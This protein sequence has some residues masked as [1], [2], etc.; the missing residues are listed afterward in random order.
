MFMGE[1]QHALDDKGRLTIPAKFRDGLGDNFIVTRGLDRCLFVYPRAEWDTMEEKVKSLP[2]AQADA[3]AFVRLLFSGAVEAELDKQG[4]VGL[5]QTLRAY[6][7]IERDVVVIGV[8]TRAEIWSAEVWSEY[9]GKAESSFG[10]MAEK[11]VGLG[12]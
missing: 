1:F 9:A 4:R 5:P 12:I 7:E 11:I 10:E 6:A 8:S 2:T 3:R